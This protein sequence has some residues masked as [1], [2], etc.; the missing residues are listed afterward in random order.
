MNS[1]FNGCFPRLYERQLEV[2][3][4]LLETRGLGDV[5]RLGIRRSLGI[6]ELAAVRQQLTR[7]VE[8]I[9]LDPYPRAAG[10]EP[11]HR[12]AP[13]C[14]GPGQMECLVADFL[15]G[16]TTPSD[17]VASTIR[18]CADAAALEPSANVIA[19][20]RYEEAMV[21][22][23]AATDLYRSQSPRL[24]QFEGVPVLVK[25][26]HDVAG[27]QTRF[28][29]AL[30]QPIAT[31][32]STLVSRL[33][34]AGMIV[35]GKTVMTE[36]GLSPIGCN[37][38][39]VM[40]RN[41]HHAGRVAGGSS[42]GSAVAVARGLVP[43]ATG[44]DAGG[45]IRLP[46]SF[47]GVLGLKPTFGRVSTHGESFTG[48]FNHLGAFARTVPDLVAFLRVGAAQPDPLDPSTWRG[49]ATSGFLQKDPASLR[50]GV[51]VA[52]WKGVAPDIERACWRAIDGL[53]AQ[54]ATLVDLDV[55]LAAHAPALGVLGVACEGLA[56]LQEMGARAQDQAG[57]SVRVA[58]ASAKGISAEELW[59]VQQLRSALRDSVRDCFAKSG[60]HRIDVWASPTVGITAP[61][62]LE[63]DAIETYMAPHLLRELTRHVFLGN[64]TGLPALSLPVG[65]DSSGI[66]IGLQLMC[67]AW[68]EAT[69]LG[70]A[71]AVLGGSQQRPEERSKYAA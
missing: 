28:G 58:F 23:R 19:T 57:V 42:T 62:F 41:A 45:S 35:V 44:A 68:H 56:L 5:L 25:D 11:P 30:S 1:S 13:V 63:R 52:D 59:M 2:L 60:P 12:Q 67:D 21:E 22:A 4:R 55:P 33:R 7:L 3:C 38:H 70:V 9:A 37:K 51:R 54:G 27:L 34:G 49:P 71:D 18:A 47:N 36:W 15:A 10:E 20:P 39:Y 69:L 53:V 31:T 61:L 6:D 65:L 32:D 46:A 17:A 48:T 40:P 29:S 14:I 66:P 24:R 64:L 43:L 16:R 50:I 8:P 26:Q